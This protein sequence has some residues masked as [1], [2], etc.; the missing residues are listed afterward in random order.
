MTQLKKL[1]RLNLQVIFVILL[2]IL[3]LANCSEE[4]LGIKENSESKLVKR[5]KRHVLQLGRSVLRSTRF[6]AMKLAHYGNWCGKGGNRKGD[7]SFIDG[8]D[9][10]CKY[11]DACY[12]KIRLDLPGYEPARTRYDY[13]YL[14]EEDRNECLDI[15]RAQRTCLC[16][17]KFINCMK[18]EPCSPSKVRES[19][20]YFW[21]LGL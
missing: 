16:D 3:E 4:G 20:S 10:C 13:R 7:G 21:W 19:V 17:Q 6:N 9:L 5:K 15:G 1:H 18:K 11:H 12:F 2:V 14:K 8:C